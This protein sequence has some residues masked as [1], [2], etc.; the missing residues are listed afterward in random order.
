MHLG[1]ECEPEEVWYDILRMIRPME[2][3]AQLIPRE[4]DLNAIG[5]EAPARKRLERARRTPSRRSR[6]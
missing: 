2:R 1:I 4:R 3:R 6:G 5:L